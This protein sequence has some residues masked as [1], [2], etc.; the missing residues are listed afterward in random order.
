GGRRGLSPRPEPG[1]LVD[2]AI[3]GG[4]ARL[5]DRPYEAGGGPGGGG[6]PIR[7]ADVGTGSGAIAVAIAVALRHRSVTMGRHV[8]ILATE[9]LP[10]ALQLARENAVAHAAA[11]GIRFVEADLF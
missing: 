6:D 7:I 3:G 5:S 4:M 8:T 10:E 1:R 2:I 9:R 11:V